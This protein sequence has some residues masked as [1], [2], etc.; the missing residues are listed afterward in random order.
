MAPLGVCSSQTTTTTYRARTLPVHRND[1][2]IAAAA[3]YPLP[4]GGRKPSVL[5]RLSGSKPMDGNSHL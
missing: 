3:S 4:S 2:R 1:V 5:L